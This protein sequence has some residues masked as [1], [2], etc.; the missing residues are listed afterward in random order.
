MKQSNERSVHNKK[1]LV[2]FMNNQITATKLLCNWKVDNRI[3]K[4][5]AKAC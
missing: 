3:T 1:L 4:G 2:L 5:G